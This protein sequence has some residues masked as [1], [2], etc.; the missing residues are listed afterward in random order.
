L[1]FAFGLAAAFNLGSGI[2][3]SVRISALVAA[4]WSHVDSSYIPF[5]A[6]AAP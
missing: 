6:L 1:G 5:D 2:A 4:S 3:T